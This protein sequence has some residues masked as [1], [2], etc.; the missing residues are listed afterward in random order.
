VTTVANSTGEA[1]VRYFSGNT[2]VQPDACG[3]FVRMENDDSILAGVC[4][5]WGMSYGKWDH[6]A[7]DRSYNHAFFVQNLYH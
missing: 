7:D 4:G 5:Q 2:D 6:A 3:S 1:V